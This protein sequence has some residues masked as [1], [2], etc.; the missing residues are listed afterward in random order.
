MI[1][2]SYGWSVKRYRW[3]EDDRNEKGRDLVKR[4]N[5]LPGAGQP[6]KAFKA[7]PG[8]EKHC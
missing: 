8:S 1:C 6:C 2:K 3:P 5:A 4:L 7:L